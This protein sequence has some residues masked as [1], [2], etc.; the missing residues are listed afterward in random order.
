MLKDTELIFKV[1]RKAK[2]HDVLMIDVGMSKEKVM[3]EDFFSNAL[4]KHRALD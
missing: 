4:N 3:S 2:R 1:T